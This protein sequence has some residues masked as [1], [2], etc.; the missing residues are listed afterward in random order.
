MT[1]CGPQ[2]AVLPAPK[3]ENDRKETVGSAEEQLLRSVDVHW[4][5]DWTRPAAHYTTA[6][7]AAAATVVYCALQCPPPPPGGPLPAKL[8]NVL[9]QNNV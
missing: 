7:A 6:A 3:D 4:Q 9:R 8:A 1:A 5:G 2:T